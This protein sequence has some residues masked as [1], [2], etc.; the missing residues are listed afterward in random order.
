M[1]ERYVT[2][3]NNKLYEVDLNKIGEDFKV[4]NL[5]EKLK[6]ALFFFNY[7][8]IKPDFKQNED[9]IKDVEIVFKNDNIYIKYLVDY[10]RKHLG[11]YNKEDGNYY[12]DYKYKNIYDYKNKFGVFS[13]NMRRI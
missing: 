6:T 3:I 7:F 1:D 12:K 9:F 5:N 2:K 4:Y 10:K 13:S 11:F 8:D